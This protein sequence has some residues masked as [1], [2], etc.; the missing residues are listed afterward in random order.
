MVK[1]RSKTL[2]FNNI[3]VNINAI[4]EVQTLISDAFY[5]KT[6]N[7]MNYM[8]NSSLNSNTEPQ[9]MLSAINGNLEFISVNKNSLAPYS[10]ILEEEEFFKIVGKVKNGIS[11]KSG[12]YQEHLYGLYLKAKEENDNGFISDILNKAVVF[13]NNLNYVK[14]LSKNK[15][16]MKE[17]RKNFGNESP[18]YI[19]KNMGNLK[20][21]NIVKDQMQ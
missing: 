19:F 15:L 17:W 21:I 1:R 5:D 10:N 18:V 7:K 2:I 9:I 8:Y 16:F 20:L 12:K 14:T 13:R 4:K 6:F 3:D 11:K